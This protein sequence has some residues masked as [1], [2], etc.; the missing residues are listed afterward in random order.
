MSIQKLATVNEENSKNVKD[1][2]ISPQIELPFL[3]HV[4]KCIYDNTPPRFGL[5][6]EFV[7][8]FI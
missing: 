4:A 2:V 3:C 7:L 8:E 6:G 1:I 5:V